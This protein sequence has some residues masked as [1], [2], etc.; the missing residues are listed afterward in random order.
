MSLGYLLASLPMLAPDRA[1]QITAEGFCAAC[2][3]ALSAKDAE[4]ASILARGEA[5]K[6]THR[7]VVQWRDLEAAIACA[8]GQ[9]RLARR[10]GNGSIYT[11][12]E[13]AVCPVTLVRAVASAFESATDPLAREEALLRVYWDAAEEMA[14]FD[15]LSKGQI[16]AYAVRLRL[17]LQKFARNTQVGA[18]RIE[19]ALPKQTL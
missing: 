12:P 18:A 2:E 16:F 8:V 15:P 19:A 11:A 4:A 9:R 13:T 14:G 1:P 7:Y 3:S 6:S 17:L 5:V 10:G